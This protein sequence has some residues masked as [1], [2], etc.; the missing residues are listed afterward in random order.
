MVDAATIAQVE[1][2]RNLTRQVQDTVLS[3][4]EAVD[5][6]YVGGWKWVTPLHDTTT[7]YDGAVLRRDS[8]QGVEIALINLGLT[9]DGDP[10]TLDS[11][12]VKHE[13]PASYH[14]ARR[15]L[16]LIEES[17]PNAKIVLLGHSLAG[18]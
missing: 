12:W 8:S 7:G 2:Y 16:L 3:H 13:L 17:S 1:E 14:E 18:C 11:V 6:P 15:D 4:T 10:G 9:G 5:A